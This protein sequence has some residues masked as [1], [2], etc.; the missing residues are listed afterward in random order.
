[1]A[2]EQGLCQGLELA[3]P[4][5]A[6][7]TF[8]TAISACSDTQIPQ[9]P[10]GTSLSP[11]SP[12]DTHPKLSWCWTALGEVPSGAGWV[13]PW[14][15]CSCPAHGVGW[16]EPKSSPGAAAGIALPGSPTLLQQCHLVG[17]CPLHSRVPAPAQGPRSPA[18]IIPS[19]AGASGHSP[20]LLLVTG[21]LWTVRSLKQD[22]VST[23]SSTE[24]S[25]KAWRSGR[26]QKLQRDTASAGHRDW[27]ASGWDPIGLL[28]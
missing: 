13:S 15:H 16:R 17:S 25:T 6:F 22:P 28:G 3:I 14:A 1:M 11:V 27:R 23:C 10:A 18:S 8:A 26:G 12:I 4:K 24:L 2:G 7:P 21:M 19:K 5:A 20:S 9:A